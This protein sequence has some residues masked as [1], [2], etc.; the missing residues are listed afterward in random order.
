MPSG[1]S[2]ISKCSIRPRFAR[3]VSVKLPPA[4][5]QVIDVA[6]DPQVVVPHLFEEAHGRRH[7]RQKK[8]RYVDGVEWLY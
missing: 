1:Q 5:L 7:S 2:A 4:P 3:I 8:A 6:E